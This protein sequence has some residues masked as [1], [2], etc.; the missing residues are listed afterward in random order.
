ME[1][2]PERVKLL[3]RKSANLMK[4]VIPFLGDPTILQ[5]IV[6]TK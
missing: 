6:E 1:I 3:S 2:R 4:R 5:A